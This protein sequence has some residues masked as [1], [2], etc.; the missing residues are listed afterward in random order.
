MTKTLGL[1][2]TVPFTVDAFNKTMSEVMPNVEKFNILDDRILKLISEAGKLT[3]AVHR[4]VA[5][6]ACIAEDE[7]A[8]ALLV[9]CS[10]ISPC[11]DT[12]RPFVSIPVMKVDDPM[13]D[14]AV[15]KASKIGVVATAKTTLEPTKMLL[16]SK[17]EARGKEITIKAEL[18][19]GAIDALSAHDT[20]K[21]DRLVLES[22]R[23]IA[24]KLT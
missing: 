6:Y 4:I 19:S 8:N 22:I 10:S 2:Y 9:T 15:Q 13:T 5:N 16:L 20:A 21:H 7:G 17:A 23:R 3:P 24:G 11:V 12:A 18:C 1:L 14:L